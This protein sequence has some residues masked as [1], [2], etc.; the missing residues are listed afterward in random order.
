M[1]CV[2]F[3]L[4]T[5]ADGIALITLDPPGRLHVIDR[6]VIEELSIYEVLPAFVELCK[7]LESSC[8]VRFAF[9]AVDRHGRKGGTPST[10]AL[11]VSARQPEACKLDDLHRR[12]PL[13]M[14][15]FGARTRVLRGLTPIALPCSR[16]VRSRPFPSESLYGS[17]PSRHDADRNARG[18]R[19]VV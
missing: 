7:W 10:A 15:I 2:N 1:T 18:T 13:P 12:H 9:K 17:R 3:K 14:L 6:N 8:G 4:E 5:D 16:R 11:Q 19:R